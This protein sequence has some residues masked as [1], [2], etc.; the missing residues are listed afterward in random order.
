MIHM[1]LAAAAI[2]IGAGLT[3]RDLEFRGC[4]TDSRTTAPG[5]LFIAIK[6]EHFDGHDFVENAG[7]RGAC[8][9]LVEKT[10]ATHLPLLVVGNTR[11]AMGKLAHQWRRT[12]D[13]PVVAV[14]GSNGKT[15]VKEILVNILGLQAPVLATQGNLNND[16][17]VPLTLFGFGDEHRYAVI[18]MGA[19]HPGEILWLSEITQPTVSLITQC[20]PAHLQGFGT[21]EGVAMAK[22]EIF[23]G[24]D[25]NGVAI[26]NADDDFADMWRARTKTFRQISFGLDQDA[27]IT[28]CLIT[29]SAAGDGMDF[30]LCTPAGE[31]DV[32]LKLL[33]R[34]N[35]MNALAATACALGLNVG[36]DVIRQGLQQ[37]RPVKGRLQKKSG[38]N[39][40]TVIDDTY[41]ANPG[42]LAAALNVV[43]PF[44]GRHWLALGDMGELGAGTEALHAEA[45]NIAKRSGMER[46][47]AIGP[48]SS[49]AVRTF[50]AGAQHFTDI[51]HLVTQVRAEITSDVTILVKGSRAM[52]MERVVRGLE[53]AN[54]C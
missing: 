5:E 52:Q 31:I 45:G 17:G 32:S 50:G 14:T 21:V 13:V 16:I 37:I 28:A 44:A 20:A 36:L 54:T 9:A 10:I 47:F 42:S 29:L 22:A 46:L 2:S 48:L 15:T 49:A 7:K 39:H 27:D 8:A 6:G 43:K 11:Q 38:L 19:N 53:A 4:S 3:V 30:V 18:E 40:S 41:N 24:L 12:F 25:K 51:T 26:I 33:G 34:H 23:S 1:T 35:V